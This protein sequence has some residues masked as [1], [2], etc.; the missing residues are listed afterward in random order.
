MKTIENQKFFIDPKNDQ[1]IELSDFSIMKNSILI[2]RKRTGIKTRI[3]HLPSSGIVLPKNT[4]PVFNAGVGCEVEN[5]TFKFEVPAWKFIIRRWWCKNID[6]TESKTG[7][8]VFIAAIAL[9]I[10]YCIILYNAAMMRNDVI[11]TF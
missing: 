2:V 11:G 10:F 9:F 3:Y 7:I 6:P 4:F 8:I 5:C 1:P